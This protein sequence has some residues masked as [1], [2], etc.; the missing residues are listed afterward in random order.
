MRTLRHIKW[1]VKLAGGGLYNAAIG[2]DTL[3]DA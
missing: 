1:E 3:L 2:T